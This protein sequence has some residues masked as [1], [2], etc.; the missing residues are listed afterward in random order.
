VESDE[1]I[2][3]SSVKVKKEKNEIIQSS[4]DRIL[5]GSYGWR[6]ILARRPR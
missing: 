5:H 6:D 4:P 3:Q 1:E 2:T